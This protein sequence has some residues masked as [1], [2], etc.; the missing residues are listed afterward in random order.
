MNSNQIINAMHDRQDCSNSSVC[1]RVSL[2]HQLVHHS[3]FTCNLYIGNK[4]PKEKGKI[5][6]K[7][8]F[9]PPD[10]NN[11]VSK[12]TGPEGK[13]ASEFAKQPRDSE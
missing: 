6:V 8:D 11:V 10:S 7:T 2:K 3:W 4:K 13:S 9:Q 5:K 1:I 12:S